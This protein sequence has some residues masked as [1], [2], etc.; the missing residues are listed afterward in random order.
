MALFAIIF[1]LLKNSIYRCKLEDHS[2]KNDKYAFI[3]PSSI[4]SSYTIVMTSTTDRAK[5]KADTKTDPT[6]ILKRVRK[7][8]VPKL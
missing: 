7:L 3:M 4:S 1:K 2:E 6:R 5:S 8:L